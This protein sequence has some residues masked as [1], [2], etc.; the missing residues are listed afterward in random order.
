MPPFSS[1]RMPGCKN[2]F[3]PKY[4]GSSHPSS[5]VRRHLMSTGLIWD[6]QQHPLL[7]KR[8]KRGMFDQI[9]KILYFCTD[10]TV[11]L[12]NPP[13]LCWERCSPSH[14][15]THA[16]VV[17]FVKW[18]SLLGFRVALA[19]AVPIHEYKGGVKK[20]L[21]VVVEEKDGGGASFCIILTK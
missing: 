17:F 11:E 18:S 4:T 13:P 10:K 6:H 14:H 2:I 21:L 20:C 7:T 19:P 5:L 9:K 12:Q 1:R 8:Q 15:P 3:G 16:A